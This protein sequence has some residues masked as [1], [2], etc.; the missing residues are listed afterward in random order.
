MRITDIRIQARNQNRANVSVDGVYRLSLDVYQVGE[1]GIKKGSEVDE[2]T[3]VRL[4]GESEYGKLYARTLEYCLLRPHSQREVR[5]YLWRKTRPTKTRSKK[6]GELVERRGVSASN[7]DRVL[8]RLIDKGY[9]DDEKFARFW[10]ENRNQAKGSSL[11]KISLE[12]RAK[13]VDQALIDQAL[14]TSER[15]DAAEIR[16]IIAKKRRRYPDDQKLI[17]YLARQGFRF[18]DIKSAL[19]DEDE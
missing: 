1:L 18:D 5:D 9:I 14:G 10:G 4:E 17:Q 11:K 15:S 16:K 8:E 3:L 19:A 6:T 12:L 7:V 13:G 2:A